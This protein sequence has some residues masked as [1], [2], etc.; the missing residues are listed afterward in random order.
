MSPKVILG[1]VAGLVALAG[2]F[3]AGIVTGAIVVA[4]IIGASGGLARAPSPL[5]G[6]PAPN[7]SATTI[8]G[9]TVVFSDFEGRNVLLVFWA[10]WCGPCTAEIPDLKAV[11]DEYRDREDFVIVGVNLDD[12]IDAA[13]THIAEY[14]LDWMQL[15]E[16]GKGWDNVVAQMYGV[17]GIPSI[18]LIDSE[19]IVYRDGLRGRRIGS[20]TRKLLERADVPV[21]GLRAPAGGA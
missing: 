17:R 21:A 14:D 8:D 19:G 20:E 18:W 13:R 10:S 11:A 4:G 6:R 7:A 3:V 16:E 1:V 9:E 5:V 12:D 2:A 15:H